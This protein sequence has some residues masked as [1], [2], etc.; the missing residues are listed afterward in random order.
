MEL[1]RIFKPDGLRKLSHN[2]IP[3][4]LPH[5][6]EQI[7]AIL[8]A[9]EPI[10]RRSPSSFLSPVLHGPTG[11]GK[12]TTIRKVMEIVI[13]ELNDMNLNYLHINCSVAGK[14]FVVSQRISENISVSP[15]RGYS[16][17]EM[18]RRAYNELE[19]RDEYLLLVLDDLDDLIRR[20]GGRLLLML[21]RI[22][23]FEM[24]SKRILPILIVRKLEVLNLLDKALISKL[25][26]PRIE[27]SPYSKDEMR[28]IIKQRV[29][30]AFNPEAVSK[31]A[32]E[33]ISFNSAFLG[34]GD[35]RYGINLLQRSGFVALAR[36]RNKVLTDHVREAQY[37]LDNRIPEGLIKKLRDNGLVTL[38]AISDC[39]RRDPDKYYV[40]VDEVFEKALFFAKRLLNK[41]I[42]KKEI[43]ESIN[44]LMAEGVIFMNEK[45]IVMPITSANS[46]YERLINVI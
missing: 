20:E 29:E 9:L 22:E 15:T 21:S 39:F 6:E 42:S 5:R 23:E 41:G 27:F 30:L 12:T 1:H 14:T 11:T 37:Q 33:Q 34:G 2:F 4:S 17:F 19:L 45:G 13:R 35:A 26:G 10:F 25:I 18:L 40:Y 8:N 32:I 3:P 36:G 16:D 44:F 43:E 46:L 31:N 28:S 7:D 24:A 38:I